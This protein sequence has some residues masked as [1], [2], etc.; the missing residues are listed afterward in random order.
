M[1]NIVKIRFREKRE[2]QNVQRE[3]KRE[4]IDERKNQKSN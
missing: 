3:I 4:G 2:K 1:K